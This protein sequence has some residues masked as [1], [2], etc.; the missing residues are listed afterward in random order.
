MTALPGMAEMERTAT[1][2]DNGLHRYDLTR[3]WVS[4]ADWA[5]FV[6]LN[7]STADASI[8]DPTIRR[9]VGF[10]RREGYGGLAVVNLF[11][12]RATNP[13]DLADSGDA[14]IDT[15]GRDNGFHIGRWLDAASV[16]VAA[17]GAHPMAAYRAA[18]FRSTA[19]GF[20]KDLVCLGKTKSGAPRH[21]LYVSGTQP[22]VEWP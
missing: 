18:F 19:R 5:V 4:G 2:S 22:L 12:L 16:V 15:V 14:G 13:E 17:W 10:A 1:I 3:R 6:M 11:A 8:D 21:P 20:D 9:C 7:P